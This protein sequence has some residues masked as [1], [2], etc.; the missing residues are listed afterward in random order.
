MFAVLVS[1]RA[2]GAAWPAWAVGVVLAIGCGEAGTGTGSD[3]SMTGSTGEGTSDGAASTTGEPTT[4]VVEE[5][6]P[7]TACAERTTV[8]A[9]P[10][11][12]GEAVAFINTLP[13]PLSL[14]C[15]LE[16]LER[17][18]RIAGTSSVV[19]LQPAVG[20]HSPR[21]FLFLGDALVMSITVGD[22]F[23][24]DLLE[25][26]EVIAPARSIKGEVA[27]PVDDPLA[28]SAPFTRILEED[29]GR[30]DCAICHRGEASVPDYPFAFASTVLRFREEEEVTL[31]ALHDEHER[32]DPLAQPERCAR[33]TA[34]LGHGPVESAVFAVDL[35]TIYDQE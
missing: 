31:S 30:T 24:F 12:I 26:G 25:F 8:T 17:P 9:S 4:G 15:F 10:R 16:R 27:F 7:P 32:C 14:D 6:P 19:S 28:G 22:K 29:T 18:L 34:L 13:R 11:T 5:E 33:L 3:A 1:P 20:T 21:V 35:P 23:G 2:S